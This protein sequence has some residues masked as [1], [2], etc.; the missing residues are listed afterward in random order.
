MSES[1]FL[2]LIVI[3]S[4]L[5]FGSIEAWAF[6]MV[7]I[8]V[9]IYFNLWIRRHEIK[10]PE[11]FLQRMFYIGI[12]G[13]L[14]Y[15]LLQTVPLPSELLKKLSPSTHA[16]LSSLSVENPHSGI[17]F[18]PFAS[19]NEISKLVV[20][21]MIFFISLSITKRRED[22]R[23]VLITIVI[24][25]CILSL[26]AIIQKATWNGKIYWFRELSHGGT[27]FGPF[28]NR[29]HFAGFVGMVIPVGLGLALD[30]EKVEK[31][32]LLIFLSLVSTLGL[33]YSLSRGGIMSFLLST[34][35]FISLSAIKGIRKRSTV[36]IVIFFSLLIL[37]L[38]YLGMSPIIERF[39]RGGL[40]DEERLKIWLATGK[41]ISDFPFFGIGLG[42]FRYIIPMYY[43][44][45]LQNDIYYAHNDY[46][47]VLLETGIIGVIFIF[48]S[49]SAIVVMVIKSLFMRRGPNYIY[50]GLIASVV[51]ITVHSVFDFNLHMPS[52]AIIFSLLFGIL[53]GMTLS[54]LKRRQDSY[55]HDRIY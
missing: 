31:K 14:I 49:F 12:F 39:A 41:A 53:Y 32:L 11:P 22:I 2:A 5:L 33:F 9:V 26:F 16:L 29:N 35:A 6:G 46:L 1:I 27:P 52:N 4:V 17:S 19:M 20:Y 45:T 40:T 42:T 47:Q 7:G 15:C 50:M 25:A 48:I 51:Y 36:Y 37:Y 8:V 34:G 13:F 44:D 54:R 43:P 3:F 30:M 21:I 18:Y 23:R 28:V 10:I 55:F 24:F 38:L